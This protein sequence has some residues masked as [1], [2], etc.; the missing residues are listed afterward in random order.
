MGASIL[1]AALRTS[2]RLAGAD[3]PPA[4]A[5]AKVAKVANAIGPELDG[6]SSFST[7]FSAHIRADDGYVRHADA[8]T[9]W[10]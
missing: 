9:G 2:L 7:V 4:P 6:S 1:A 3:H 10:R 8:G 5:V